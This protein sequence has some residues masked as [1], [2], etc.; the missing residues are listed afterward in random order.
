MQQN[1]AAVPARGSV[2][3]VRVRA[4]L[5]GEGHQGL[6]AGLP[7]VGFHGALAA[8]RPQQP[9][10]PK[11]AVRQEQR[12][13]APGLFVQPRKQ[14]ESVGAV[15][16]VLLDL[17][18][19][20]RARE[21]RIPALQPAQVRRLRLRADPLG[22]EP[23]HL[24]HQVVIARREGLAFAGL[25]FARPLVP[26]EPQRAAP[27][28]SVHGFSSSRAPSSPTAFTFWRTAVADTRTYYFFFFFFV[29][30]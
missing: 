2:A 17:H 15:R 25:F 3:Q 19:A 5:E 14:P 28:V 6:H 1:L 24:L 16:Q 26:L 29:F 8:L 9:Q 7:F 12:P 20:Q 18:G 21:D 13:F 10:V 4:R 22:D 27:F 11:R 30:F 23:G